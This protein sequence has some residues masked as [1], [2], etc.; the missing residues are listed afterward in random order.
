MVYSKSAKLIEKANY[1]KNQAVDPKR[2]YW[3]SEIGFNYRMTNM[4][5]AIGLAQLEQS[6]IILEKNRTW[7][8]NTKRI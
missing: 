6:E 8:S 3:H 7:P 5:A 4:Q 1:L 2:E